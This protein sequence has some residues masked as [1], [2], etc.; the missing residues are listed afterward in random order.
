MLMVPLQEFLAI[1]NSETNRQT[2]NKKIM[3][4]LIKQKLKCYKETL[5]C[6]RKDLSRSGW[7]VPGIAMETVW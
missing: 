4:N 6:L 1:V 2:T 5:T 7:T 3:E